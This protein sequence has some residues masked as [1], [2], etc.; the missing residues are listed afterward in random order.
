MYSSERCQL[1][2][3]WPREDGPRETRERRPS[4]RERG[5][6]HTQ[7]IR[8]LGSLQ[9]EGKVAVR[10]HDWEAICGVERRI[11]NFVESKKD[12]KDFNDAARA[13]YYGLTKALFMLGKWPELAE[14]ARARIDFAKTTAD[15]ELETGGW[16]SLINAQQKQENWKELV[17]TGKALLERAQSCDSGKM[18]RAAYRA[19]SD[20]YIQ[21]KDWNALRD[22]ARCI[23]ESN[24]NSKMNSYAERILAMAEAEQESAEHF[25]RS[26][27]ESS[28]EKESRDELVEIRNEFKPPSGGRGR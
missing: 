25:D 5:E 21:L 10:I 14:A 24:L 27:Y 28:F 15:V 22:I 17:D 20:A 3:K 18:K 7:D 12:F 8:Y 4:R 1:R 9:K 16:F 19:L 26:L 11:L 13:A 23:S 2:R 6:Q